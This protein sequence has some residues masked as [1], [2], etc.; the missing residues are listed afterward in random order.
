MAR[1]WWVLRL[2]APTSLVLLVLSHAADA[3]GQSRTAREF[4]GFSWKG[5][6]GVHG[7]GPRAKSKLH[8][9]R[10]TPRCWKTMMAATFAPSA[11][12]R[13]L[14]EATSNPQT[15]LL[16]CLVGTYAVLWSVELGA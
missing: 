13:A 3:S 9:R 4:A 8:C 16:L 7:E 1:A 10:S 5:A 11:A 12:S 6:H 2:A 15:D 14:T